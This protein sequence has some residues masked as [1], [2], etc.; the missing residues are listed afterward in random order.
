MLPSSVNEDG[1]GVNAPYAGHGVEQG[2]LAG[3]VTADDGDKVAVGQGETD[4]PEGLFFVDGAGVKGL[5]DIP[6][7]KH[8]RR[9][10]S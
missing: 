2:G 6:N 8:G 9:P 7:L 3:A 1:A 10:P 4:A 5:V